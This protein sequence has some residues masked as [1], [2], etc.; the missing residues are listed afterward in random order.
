MSSTVIIE[1]QSTG[2]TWIRFCDGANRPATIQRLLESALRSQSW[3]KK[4]RALDSVAKQLIDI[5][6]GI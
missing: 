2:G 4:A 6:I 3:V 5:S 1:I